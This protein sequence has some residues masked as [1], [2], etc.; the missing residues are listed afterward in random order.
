MN[1]RLKTVAVAAVG[2]AFFVMPKPAQA[3]S[4]YEPYSFATFAGFPPGSADGTGSGAQ[5]NEPIGVAVDTNGN[6]Y[7]ADSRRSAR[8]LP[9]E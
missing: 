6:L 4:N 2:A 5:F 8:L 3:Q 9:P 1:I 7:V